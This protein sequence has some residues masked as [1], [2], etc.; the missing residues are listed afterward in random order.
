MAETAID[1]IYSNLGKLSAQMYS[2]L[3]KNQS[4]LMQE[5]LREY[6]LC[7]EKKI[8]EMMIDVQL[9]NLNSEM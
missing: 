1:E 2:S 6:H 5:Q 8:A 7:A 9:S 4:D 3:A